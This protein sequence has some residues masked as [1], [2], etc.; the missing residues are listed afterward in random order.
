[1]P[2]SIAKV[3]YPTRLR[4]GSDGGTFDV[5]Y[6]VQGLDPTR[7]DNVAIALTVA[8]ASTGKTIPPYS[9]PHLTIPGYWVVNLEA[10]PMGDEQSPNLS[11]VW[12]KVTYGTSNRGA[13][14][15]TI[16]ITG[17]NGRKTIARWPSGP[18]RGK[19][20]LVGYAPAG[21]S[22]AAQLSPKK[23]A[24][25]GY[26]YSLVGAEVL[27]PNTILEFDRRETRS[28]LLKSQQFR[29]R[30][31]SSA[32]QGGAPGTWLC[33]KLDG[34][35]TTLTGFQ[36][37][38]YDCSY[39]FEWDPEGWTEY[40]LFVDQN[41]GQHPQDIDITDGSYNGYTKIDYPTAD[42]GQ[43]GLPSAF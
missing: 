13:P 9:Q 21:A 4:F 31:N 39:A 15:V 5:L 22:F 37:G 14:A 33:R 24:P 29:R 41:T 28:P 16:R 7:D 17:S 30:T 36:A 19:A 35:A 42:F 2:I 34:I 8:D 18:Q 20:I 12:V 1:M 26:Y 32:W 38:F 43:L 10:Y 11:G 25:D 23:T 3:A 6:T 27:S 40:G